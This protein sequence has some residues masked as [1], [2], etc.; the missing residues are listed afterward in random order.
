MFTIVFRLLR[1]I[2]LVFSPPSILCFFFRFIYSE[3]FF[4]LWAVRSHYHKC[5]LLACSSE[6]LKYPLQTRL[7][8][9]VPLKI[10]CT[11]FPPITVIRPRILNQKGLELS[12]IAVSTVAEQHLFPRMTSYFLQYLN[13]LQSIW[14]LI[15]K[16]KAECFGLNENC[17]IVNLRFCFCFCDRKY[18]WNFCILILLNQTTVS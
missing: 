8:W 1:K 6:N 13:P 5:T 18:I 12:E 16:L 17:L 11:N 14:I 15:E 7:Q 9:S 2:K 10:I 3:S 4:Q